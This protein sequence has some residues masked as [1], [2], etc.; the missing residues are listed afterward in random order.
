MALMWFSPVLPLPAL[1]R[2]PAWLTSTVLIPLALV[3][4]PALLLR[5]ITHKK[6]PLLAVSA[7]VVAIFA[8]I[9]LSFITSSAGEERVL[10]SRGRWTMATVVEVDNGTTDEC[11]LRARDGRDISPEMTDG[12]DPKTVEEG[13]EL[14]VLYDPK[15]AA[16]PLEDDD[17][18]VDLDP[19]S[20][21]GMIGGLAVLIVVTGTCGCARLD[22]GDRQPGGGAR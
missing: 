16:A 3:L 14:H 15:G 10:E 4:V 6:T 7:L 9:G 13:D 19:G 2:G 12:C 22:R 20:Y 5:H 17:T 18:P 21:R 11:T 8:A 1:L